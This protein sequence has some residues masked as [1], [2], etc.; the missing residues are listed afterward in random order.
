MLQSHD[1]LMNLR[2]ADGEGGRGAACVHQ[3][4]LGGRGLLLCTASGVR[5]M[6]TREFRDVL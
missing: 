4:R 3:Q 2:S 6:S 5:E 1:M